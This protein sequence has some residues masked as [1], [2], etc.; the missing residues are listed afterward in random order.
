M[1]R[2]GGRDESATQVVPNA[3]GQGRYGSSDGS[4]DGWRRDGPA[5]ST[6]A[7]ERAGSGAGAGTGAQSTSDRNGTEATGVHQ[8]VDTERDAPTRPGAEQERR[9]PPPPSVLPQEHTDHRADQ[10]SEQRGERG[11]V[12]RA[13]LRAVRLDPWSVMKTSFLLSIAAGIMLLVAVAVIWKV[14]DTAGVYDA[15]NRTVAD[16]LGGASNAHFNIN[17]YIGLRRVLGFTTLLCVVDV[18]LIT[19]LSTLAAFLYNLSAALLGGVE[20]TLAEDE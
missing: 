3:E 12:R 14:L 5:S 18:V 2:N 1:T 11:R 15:V 4:R 6:P 16:V 7:G 8:A 9:D 17:E 20:V 19:A 10:R 13:R